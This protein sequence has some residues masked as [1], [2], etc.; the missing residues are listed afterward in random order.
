MREIRKKKFV[1]LYEKNICIEKES[2]KQF[3]LQISKFLVSL[4]KNSKKSKI[5]YLGAKLNA[6]ISTFE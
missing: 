2:K 3:N 4:S 5:H 6:L 1:H